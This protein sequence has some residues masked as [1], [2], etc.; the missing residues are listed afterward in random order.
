MKKLI[1]LLVLVVTACTGTP[2]EEV[3]RS[4]NA[5][6][7]AAIEC[8]SYPTVCVLDT[9]KLQICENIYKEQMGLIKP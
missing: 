6:Q 5:C 1:I 7:S 2:Q 9:E 8:T 4:Y 3:R